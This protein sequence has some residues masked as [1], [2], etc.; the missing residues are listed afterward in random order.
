MA[1]VLEPMTEEIYGVLDVCP[2]EE[3]GWDKAE[4]Q[5]TTCCALHKMSKAE[6]RRLRKDLEE[7]NNVFDAMWAADQRA[8]RQWQKD[9]IGMGPEIWPDRAKLTTWLLDSVE[10]Y[11][12]KFLDYKSVRERILWWAHTRHVMSDSCPQCK[13]PDGEKIPIMEYSC[14]W[15]QIK[16]LAK[17][18]GEDAGT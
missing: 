15:H 17:L 18:G 8:I 2:C 16:A 7:L 4:C 9:N 14:D 5:H 13:C 1:D 3:H 12:N 11:R 6:I 10:K